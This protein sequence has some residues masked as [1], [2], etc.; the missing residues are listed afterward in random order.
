MS[1]A[2]E[3][4]VPVRLIVM[5][6]QISGFFQPYPQEEAIAGIADHIA[7][8]WDAKMRARILDYLDMDGVKLEPVVREALHRVKAS[9]GDWDVR[10]K[11]G[12]NE[13]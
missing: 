2:V 10:D 12:K 1:V 5:A 11:P 4:G 3:D 9:G 13:A 6:N 7:K 8:F